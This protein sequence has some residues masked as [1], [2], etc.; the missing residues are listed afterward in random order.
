MHILTDL[1]QQSPCPV[2]PLDGFRCN[3]SPAW[4][5]PAGHRPSVADG[6]QLDTPEGAASALAT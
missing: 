4:A 2:K 1:E 6:R 3:G 5:D